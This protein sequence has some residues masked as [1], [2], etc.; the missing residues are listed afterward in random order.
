MTFLSFFTGIGGFDLG[1]EQSGMECV[2]QVERD[3]TCQL[4]LNAHWPAVP[5]GNDVRTYKHTGPIPDVIC[6]GFPCQDLSVAGKR[7]GLAGERSGLWFAFR[8]VIASLKPRWV[9]IEN[10]PGLLSSNEGRDFAV[11]LH[12][13]GE[14]GYRFAS[15]VL[16]SQYDGVAQRRRRVFIVGSLGNG[17]CAEVLFEPESLRRHPAPSRKAGEGVAGTLTKGLGSGG[18]K[19][20]DAARG[21][22]VPDTCKTLTAESDASPTGDGRG[23]EIVAHKV[24]H[25]SVC[26]CAKGGDPTTDNYV[27]AP[28]TTKSY[29]DNDGQ[30]DKL[31]ITP[32][33]VS[34][35]D[36]HSGF[37]DE[38]GLVAIGVDGSDVG[39]ALR[40]SGSHSGDKGDGGMNTTTVI[41]TAQTSSNG[42][43]L[44]KETAYTL[45]GTP[46]TSRWLVGRRSP[47][48]SQRMRA[49]PRISRQLHAMGCEQDRDQR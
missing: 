10:V 42:C 35:G 27:V 23:F 41:R 45:D 6:G 7:K 16:D 31:I 25:D 21:M 36:A 38:K 5:K 32:S 44:N 33:L 3:K 26:H 37:R 22:Y 40:A 30:E 47:I 13:L 15:R 18:P 20:D 24:A 39:F 43:G 4:V 2:G 28:L 9:V 14:L 12:G 17:R 8:D 46:G 29:A 1:F 34:N 11:L 48:N 49:T 19:D